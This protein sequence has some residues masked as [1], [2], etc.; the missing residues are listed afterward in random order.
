RQLVDE[1]QRGMARKRGIEIEFFE[2]SATVL[3]AAARQDL[4]AFEERF[5]LG[6]VMRFHDAGHDVD[7]A[8]TLRPSCLQHRVRLADAS[9]EAEEDLELAAAPA[10]VLLSDADEQLIG[11]GPSVR[12]ANRVYRRTHATRL[13]YGARLR[14]PAPTQARM[15]PRHAQAI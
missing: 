15:P 13:L 2:G 12:H 6:A 14:H 10:C 11:I 5:R 9:R 3:H 7:P 1:Q 8:G 4:E